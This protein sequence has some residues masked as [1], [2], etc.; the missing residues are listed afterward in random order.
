MAIKFDHA[1]KYNGKYYPANTPIEEVEKPWKYEGPATSTEEAA[2]KAEESA[3]NAAAEAA[4]VEGEANTP[5]E[6]EAAKKAA[7]GRKKGDA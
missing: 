6:P 4:A 2:K 3:E 7:K 5:A 1:V